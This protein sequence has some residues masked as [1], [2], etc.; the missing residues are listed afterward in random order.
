MDECVHHDARI[1][2]AEGGLIVEGDAERRIGS[3]HQR[4]MLED[5]IVDAQGCDLSWIT[6]RDVALPCKPPVRLRRSPDPRRRTQG[7]LRTRGKRPKRRRRRCADYTQ[8][9]PTS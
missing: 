3:R 6:A 1:G 4:V 7:I 8:L 5:R 9:H 2:Q